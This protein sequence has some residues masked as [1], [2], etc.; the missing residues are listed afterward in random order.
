MKVG[1]AVTDL[2]TGLYAKGAILAA[3]L[4]RQQ[5]GHGQWIQCNLLS[6][7][8]HVHVITTLCV[9]SGCTHY[10]TCCLTDST[11]V[12]NQ[13]FSNKRLYRCTYIMCTG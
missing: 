4:H 8:V 13:N 12:C 10:A 9:Q 11:G 6:S 7:Q 1:V 3:L 5:T 2:S